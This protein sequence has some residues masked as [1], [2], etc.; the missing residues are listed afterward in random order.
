MAAA[1]IGLRPSP[2][3]VRDLQ[4]LLLLLCILHA[5]FQAG[6]QQIQQRPSAAAQQQPGGSSDAGGGKGSGG[7]GRCGGHPRRAQRSVQLQPQRLAVVGADQDQRSAQLGLVSGWRAC[8]PR[9]TCDGWAGQDRPRR[10]KQPTREGRQGPA[11]APLVNGHHVAVHLE[12]W[13]PHQA[14]QLHKSALHQ[15]LQ[16]QL[17]RH[18]VGA[19]PA[20]DGGGGGTAWWPS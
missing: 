13:C 2:A 1:D 9:R 8:D 16:A 3:H 10:R 7:P 19:K 4:L 15:R 5:V 17:H 20:G 18:A 14:V 12:G 11:H 6:A